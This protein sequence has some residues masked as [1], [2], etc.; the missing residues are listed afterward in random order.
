MRAAAIANSFR[1]K[2]PRDCRSLNRRQPGQRRLPQGSVKVAEP[3]TILMRSFARIAEPDYE[4]FSL[5][6]GYRLLATGDR[7]RSERTSGN[8]GSERD[9]GN[10]ATCS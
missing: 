2:S 6:T 4:A 5:A 3:K 1:G 10:T 8:A 7:E 9:C